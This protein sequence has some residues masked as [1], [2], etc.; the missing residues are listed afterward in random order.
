MSTTQNRNLYSVSLKWA[1][2][3]RGVCHRTQLIRVHIIFK[4]F[5]VTLTSSSVLLMSSIFVFFFF[6][7]L[8]SLLFNHGVL[9]TNHTSFIV[10]LEIY[11]FLVNACRRRK[12]EN[13]SAKRFYVCFPKTIVLAN[14]FLPRAAYECLSR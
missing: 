13:C 14:D 2:V 9:R 5:C 3:Q 4:F 11:V 8:S 1:P 7:V 10:F 6:M 12:N